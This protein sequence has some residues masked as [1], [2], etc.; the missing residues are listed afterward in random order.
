MNSTMRSKPVSAALC[1][2]AVAC[3]AGLLLAAAAG[4]CAS[5]QAA[6]LYHD[7]TAALD[8]GDAPQAIATLE[9][10]AALQPGASEIQ[11]HLGLAH[12]AVGD[13]AAAHGAFQRAV[14]LDCDN[15]AASSNLADL[16]ALLRDG[17]ASQRANRT[18]LPD[19]RV[20]PQETP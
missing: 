19:T 12:L 10:A 3:L 4:G 15:R 13:M 5:L 1:R 11:N 14:D 9:R 7:G 17:A 2:C 8:R 18:S 6:R 20:D 16:E